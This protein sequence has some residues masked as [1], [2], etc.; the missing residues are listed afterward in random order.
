MK[1]IWIL[2]D[3]IDVSNMLKEIDTADDLW[4]FDTVRQDASEIHRH[5]QSIHIQLTE[6]VTDA[7]L[8]NTYFKTDNYNRFPIIINWLNKSFPAGL[9]RISI[10]KLFS[11]QSVISHIDV[12]IYYRKRTRFHLV[13]KGSY[14]YNVGDEC[15]TAKA[16]TLFSF[17]NSVIHHSHNLE[18]DDRIAIVFDVEH[19]VFGLGKTLINDF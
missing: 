15:I 14:T 9:A 11:K 12:G 13:I 18:K 8:S 6:S 7:N 1:H 19:S 17:N 4:L 2:S 10:I 5:T 3:T 16:G